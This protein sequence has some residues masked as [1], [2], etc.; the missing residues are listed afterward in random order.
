MTCSLFSHSGLD[1]YSNCLH[2]VHLVPFTV[3][4]YWSPS[5]V[6]TLEMSVYE[7]ST[8]IWFLGSLNVFDQSQWT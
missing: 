8:C 2:F 6:L 4:K 3:R 1:S 7:Q 5:D